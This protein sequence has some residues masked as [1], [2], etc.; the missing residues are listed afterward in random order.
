MGFE[1]CAAINNTGDKIKLEHTNQFLNYSLNL[2]PL[3]SEIEGKIK[4]QFLVE[5]LKWFLKTKNQ[6]ISIFQILILFI[7]IEFE[8]ASNKGFEDF[9]TW[10][11]VLFAINMI[12]GN[13]QFN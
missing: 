4:F 10:E 6:I 3:E 8:I 2:V 11:E 13:L 9:L 12:R 1:K 7:F 5:F